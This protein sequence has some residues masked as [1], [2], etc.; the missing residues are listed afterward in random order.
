VQEFSSAG[1]FIAA[2]GSEG[3]SN[4]Q[5]SS[6]K[7]IAVGPTGKIFIADSGNNRVEE[8]AP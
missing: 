2:F 4:G 1:A 6:P 3:S 8:W 7:G 5:L